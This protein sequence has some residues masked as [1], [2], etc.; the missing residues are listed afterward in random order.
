MNDKKTIEPTQT[1][2]HWTSAI[3]ISI[4]ACGIFL[5]CWMAKIFAPIWNWGVAFSALPLLG[6][7]LGAIIFLA[8]RIA[9]TYLFNDSPLKPIQR[10]LIIPLIIVLGLLLCVFCFLF[11]EQQQNNLR[12]TSQNALNHLSE[13]FAVLIKEQTRTLE[14]IGQVILKDNQVR[15]AIMAKDRSRLL[16][17]YQ[18][19]FNRLRADMGITHLYFVDAS[20]T[21]LLRV[22]KP[23]KYGDKIDRYT[24]KQAEETGK[25]SAGLELG[26]LGTFTLRAVQPIFDSGK[27]I[28]Y[29]ELGKEIE[30]ALT[31]LHSKR[32]IELAITIYKSYLSR[33][34][35]ESGMALLGRQS[36]WEHFSK[37]ALI[38]SSLTPFPQSAESI[39]EDK[40]LN[41]GDLS[42]ETSFDKREWRF[43]STPL[44]DVSGAE[45]GKMLMFLDITQAVSNQRH[46]LAVGLV[47]MLMLCGGLFGFLYSIL[48]RLDSGIA[49][50]QAELRKS[51]EK[52]HKL[53]ADSPDAYLIIKEGIIV[54]CNRAAESMLAGKRE[55]I[56]GKSP[57]LLSPPYQSNGQSSAL[58]AA[59][60]IAEA[61]KTGSNTF[62]WT[63]RRFDGSDFLVEVSVSSMQMLGQD[64]LLVTWRD[65]T[66]RKQAEESLRENKASLDLAL[67]SAD[68]GAWHLDIKANKRYFDEK[69]CQLLGIDPN[70][71]NGT[72]E[73]FYKAIHPDDH[74]NIKRALQHSIETGCLYEPIYRAIW[75]DGSQH[76][77]TARGKVI[78]DDK[79]Q[80]SRIQG[81]VWDISEKQQA[82]QRLQNS[83]A[84]LKAFFNLSADFLTVLSE[85]GKIL[86]VNQTL[87][88]RLGYTK[89]ELLGQTVLRLHP[90]ELQEEASKIVQA[91]IK[92]ERE[93]CPLP[94]VAKNGIKIPVETRIVK[95]VWNG[96]V[97]LFG[98]SKDISDLALSQEKFS[99]AFEAS[100]SLMAI[101]SVDEG[102]FLDVNKAFIETLGY[103]KEEIIGNTSHDLGLFCSNTI[104]EQ[105]K[106]QII[107]DGGVSNV[108]LEIRTKSGETRIGQFSAQTIRIQDKLLLLT[109]MND[110]SEIKRIQKSLVDS[111]QKL[112]K[113]N[114]S[115][116]A[117]TFEAQSMAVKAEIASATKSEFLANMSHEI[118]TPMNG[119]IGMAGLLIDTELNAEQRQYAE[120]IRTSGQALLDLINDI[121]DLSK[122]EAHKLVLEKHPF[123]LRNTMDDLA[124]M[125]AV[126]AHQK[127]LELTCQIDHEVPLL[128][129]G[130]SHRLRQILVNLCGNAV[131]FTEKG[132]ISLHASLEKEDSDKVI[133]RFA[134]SDT[135]IGIAANV[136]GE[137]FSPFKQA[138]GSTTRKYGGTGLGLSISKHLTEM[139]GGDIGVE[140]TE[141]KGSTFWFTVT[142]EKQKSCDSKASAKNEEFH[143]SRI[144][145][146]DDHKSN[147]ESILTLLLSWGCSCE[148]AGNAEEA[149]AQI[150]AAQQGNKP[151][152]LAIIDANMPNV[153]GYELARQ[154]NSNSKLKQTSLVLLSPLGQRCENSKIEELGLKGQIF[155][156][157]RHKQLHECLLSTLKGQAYNEEPNTQNASS[158]QSAAIDRKK[159]ARILIAEDNSTNQLV[160]SSIIKKLGYKADIVANGLESLT[161]AQEKQYDLIFMD[162]Q[163]PQM[164]GYEATRRIREQ[165]NGKT[166]HDLPIIAMTAFA[167]QGD[168]DKCLQAGM[169]DYLSKPVQPQAL[170][171][172]LNLWLKD[173]PNSSCDI[174]ESP[175]AL[176]HS[177]NVSE[178]TCFDERALLDR[179]MDDKDLCA[180]LINLFIDDFSAGLESLKQIIAQGDSSSIFQRAH[181]IKGSAANIAANQI[182][183]IAL[184]MESAGKRGEL[185]PCVELLPHLERAF[186]EFKVAVKHLRS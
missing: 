147:R 42:I 180:E 93:S 146:V 62:E 61:Q 148:E 10:R 177:Q 178:V 103:S 59:E 119:V 124:D 56:I 174:K 15:P 115:L 64:V 164:D 162:C 57:D 123:D 131:K 33:N 154:I 16:S 129:N 81:V 126:R 114:K 50:Q 34:A 41:D 89:E 163:M 66:A 184:A 122:I 140:T 68:M 77:I 72:S 91:M 167:M 49:Q 58:S 144:I 19:I 97:A 183:E 161:A 20:R 36:D 145:V 2:H 46:L 7:C 158:N 112:E 104:R 150:T 153:S 121:L 31:T 100:S 151:F 138:D 92:G 86:E 101:S 39:I 143:G 127:G 142:L 53:F 27:I 54:D 84:N 186:E 25:S 71:Y 102:R 79:G 37:D 170:A 70:T 26:P 176:L 12:E 109:V 88:S 136:L 118:R 95:G 74:Q 116:E 137:L 155:K 21:C 60:R 35:W 75:P 130:D 3:L 125:M 44:K 99:K 171:Q 172:M 47:G 82:K 24:M 11:F 83:E 108:E 55:Q 134:I 78:Y 135:G 166:Q 40:G 14:A 13:D 179:C 128:L 6:V 159:Q 132:E 181:T 182:R 23:D 48:Q 157:V 76:Y 169:N 90:P 63:H 65:I 120:V 133:I 69:V 22:H 8:F 32:G 96:Q 51:E 149:L 1:T 152:H 28:G 73:E 4:T 85:S 18:P 30:D 156:P 98:A 106:N 111:Q 160:I 17:E 67:Q 29:L 9:T 43:L 105:V 38:Y 141:G 173:L 80:A 94:I 168:R 113:A 87:L 165:K 5:V 52:H 45:V 107:K 117:A 175:C 110:I 185:S 139:M